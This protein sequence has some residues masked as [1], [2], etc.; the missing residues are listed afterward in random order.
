MQ[1]KSC[2]IALIP[3]TAVSNR[4]I[5][6]SQSLS[7]ADTFFTL[8]TGRFYPHISLYMLE[9]QTVDYEKIQGIIQDIA[10]QFSTFELT[11]TN[12]HQVMGFLSIEYSIN[13]ELTK[14]QEQII[15]SCNPIRNGLREKD[16]VRLKESTGSKR[17]YFEEYG[18]PYVK[19]LFNPHITVTRFRNQNPIDISDLPEIHSFT[20]KFDKIGFF[21]SGD[22]GTCVQL[23]SAYDL[24]FYR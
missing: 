15:S 12:Y 24:N 5:A 6:T 18:Y 20:G 17:R 2:N 13:S 9:L 1:S 16:I 11:A 22:N 4:A 3:S 23:L 14:L 7:S 8:E 10:K 21:E 19:E